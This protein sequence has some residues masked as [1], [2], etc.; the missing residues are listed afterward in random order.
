MVVKTAPTVLGTLL[1]GRSLPDASGYLHEF[2]QNGS[3][4]SFI[5]FVCNHC[6]YIQHIESALA[7]TVGCNRPEGP[8]IVAVVSNDTVT[9][10]GE[11]PEA[12]A[13]Q[14]TRVGCDLPY[15]IDADQ[16]FARELGAG[17]PGLV[18]LQPGLR[19]GLSFRAVACQ[20]SHITF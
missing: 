20:K 1:Q 18:S 13:D 5:A 3:Q 16:S 12:M 15:L 11:G 4:A 17:H 9:H 8:R 7:D 10:P 14:V 6:P 2:R 19:A